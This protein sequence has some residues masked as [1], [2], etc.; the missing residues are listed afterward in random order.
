MII[1]LGLIAVITVGVW[2]LNR[3]LP[4]R[5]CPVCAG[6]SGTWFLLTAAILG[7]LLP[8]GEFFV[9]IAMLMGATVVGVAYQGEK[10]YDWMKGALWRWMVPVVIGGLAVAFWLLENMSYASLFVEVIIL[11]VLFYALFIHPSVRGST[12]KILKDGDEVKR[13]LHEM[14][15]CC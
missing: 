11:A 5:I 1:A 12:R 2:F 9:P 3:Y 15:Q 10:R 6:V 14:E 7:G 4:I 13:L 8:R